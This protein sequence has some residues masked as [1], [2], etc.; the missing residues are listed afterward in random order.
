MKGIST[1]KIVLLHKGST[2]L[3]MN[4][5][6]QSMTQWS[7]VACRLLGLPTAGCLD[8]SSDNL[9]FTSSTVIKS[10][11]TSIITCLIGFLI[12]KS[13]LLPYTDMTKTRNGLGKR[14]SKRTSGKNLPENDFW[15]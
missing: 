10:R 5:V 11:H 8:M 12:P 2:K 7:V 6:L 15:P 1:A 14:T 13:V 4:I 3:H 9:S